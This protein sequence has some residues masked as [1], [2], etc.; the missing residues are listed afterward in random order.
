MKRPEPRPVPA[1]KAVALTAGETLT[2][3]VPGATCRLTANAGGGIELSAGGARIVIEGGAV[4]VEAATVEVAA[5]N[6]RF[7]GI[8]QCETLIANAVVAASYTPGA[9]NIW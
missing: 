3:S 2:V 1:E 7:T 8:V 6:A 4:R 5:A 9:G